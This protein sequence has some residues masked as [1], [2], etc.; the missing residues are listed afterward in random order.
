LA[1]EIFMK[2]RFSPLRTSLAVLEFD[3]GLLI[4]VSLTNVAPLGA[5]VTMLTVTVAV[6]ALTLCAPFISRIDPSV[7]GLEAAVAELPE[8]ALQS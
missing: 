4:A 8:L 2:P 6:I 5:I 3:L 1:D 7:T